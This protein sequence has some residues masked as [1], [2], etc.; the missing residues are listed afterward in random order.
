MRGG[1]R[2]HLPSFLPSLS[3]SIY[4]ERQAFRRFRCVG[5]RRTM[6]PCQKHGWRRTGAIQE[7]IGR[8]QSSGRADP[9]RQLF[10]VPRPRRRSA[11]ERAATGCSRQ[12]FACRRSRAKI[13]IVPGKPDKSE[14]VRRIFADDPDERMP[15]KDS[16][17]RL[18]DAQKQTLRRWIAAGANY[19]LH[20]SFVP[21]QKAAIAGGKA[22]QLAAQPDRQ[23]R[24]R[25]ARSRRIAAV[26][27]SRPH[28]ADPP[29]QRST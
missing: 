22:G 2:S 14:L 27:G 10:Q 15:P 19:E 7:R 20:W 4:A 23:F 24:P 13:A 16:N 26:A 21:P 1:E 5:A 25:E 8:F 28:D 29:A 18:T 3:G 6:L 17:K 9:G 11:K 12:G